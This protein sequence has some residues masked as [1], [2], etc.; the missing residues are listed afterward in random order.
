MKNLFKSIFTQ[1]LKEEDKI[2]LLGMGLVIIL[3]GIV[4]AILKNF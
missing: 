1:T 2:G 4:L 3:A